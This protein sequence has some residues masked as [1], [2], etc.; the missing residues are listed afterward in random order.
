[1]AY[2]NDFVDRGR[3]KKVFLQGDAPFRRAPE[4]LERWYVRNGAGSM[5][6]Y[7]AF[8]TGSWTYGSPRLERFNGLPSVQIEGAAAP[9]YSSGD[10]MAAMEELARDLPAGFGIEWSG[11]SYE[12]RLAG[13]GAGVVRPVA[14]R[15]LPVPRR[16]LRA[17]VGALLRDAGR[18]P[19]RRRRAG[20]RVPVQAEQRRVLPG[21]AADDDRALGEERHP[22]RGV[23]ARSPCQGHGARRGGPGG[24]A[25]ALAAD[26]DDVARLHPGRAPSGDVERGGRRRAE[27]HRARGD[28]RHVVGHL[29]RGADGAH[30]LRRGP[31]PVPE[32]G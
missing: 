11:M 17:L 13:S 30:L 10:A 16:A 24:R 7:S 4:D 27:R 2:V 15:H 25:H 6:P 12:E 31:R 1:G 19:R 32:A 22:H 21:R 28:R 3:V 14:A 29:P 18:P 20:L 8:A 9:G 26:P 23:R 5:V